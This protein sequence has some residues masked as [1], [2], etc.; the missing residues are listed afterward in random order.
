MITSRKAKIELYDVK[1]TCCDGSYEMIT[2]S[3]KVDK[4]ELL[5][6]ENPGY[7]RLIRHYQH[8]NAVQMDDHDN[9]NN[10]PVHV[11][12]GSGENARIKAATKPLVGK[13]GE[14][15]AERTKF[16]W[17]ILSPGAEFDKTKM[18][19]KQTSSGL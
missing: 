12:L 13:E 16:G 6:I 14:P 10:L 19:L 4:S 1:I 5:Y 8:L 15:V 17:T 9:K 11:I 18:L 3:S 7:K 2:R